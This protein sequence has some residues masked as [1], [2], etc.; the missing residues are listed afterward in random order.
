VK[1]ISKKKDEKKKGKTA[2]SLE[3]FL[4]SVLII[5][6]L[7]TVWIAAVEWVNDSGIKKLTQE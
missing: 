7:K 5:F 4:F 3:P 2:Q 6:K 1:E